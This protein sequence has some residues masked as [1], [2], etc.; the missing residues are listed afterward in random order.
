MISRTFLP[1]SQ[2]SEEEDVTTGRKINSA[3]LNGLCP[4]SNDSEYE[5]KLRKRQHLQRIISIEEDHLP[6]FLDLEYET[7][8]TE[9]AEEEE[10][11]IT[12][13]NNNKEEEKNSTNGTPSSPR[14][15]PVG[16]ETVSSVE[17]SNTCLDRLFK[18]VFVGNSSVGKT[19]F[20]RRFCEDCFY[21]GTAA[22]VGID[23]SVKTVTVE[24]CQVAL[25]LWDTAG[26]ER[27]RS[28]TKQFF[29]K[30]DGVIIMYDIT[31]ECTFTAIRQWLTNVQEAAG[32]T[33]PVLLLG[34]KTDKE[35]EREVPTKFGE[36]IAK[37]Y[38]LIFYEC[39]AFSG[40]NTKDSMLH[41]AKILKDQEDKQ[42]EN[43]IQLVQDSPK[44]KT[45]CS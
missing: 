32:E 40:H 43:T 33:I 26:Q 41:L 8:L 42:K 17:S 19:S 36:R 29:R 9:W 23:Y 44:K 27:Y 30:A 45:C 39:S 5:S 22:T 3:S 1:L 37:D 10:R 7:N 31:V 28:I 15:Q 35:K 14:G 34:N 12:E 6:Q 4:V 18:I 2:S 13:E 16:K 20:L 25:Q 38:N 21:P 24:N 11:V